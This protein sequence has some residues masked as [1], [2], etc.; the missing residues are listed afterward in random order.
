MKSQSR[1]VGYLNLTGPTQYLTLVKIIAA[2]D[3]EDADLFSDMI[4]DRLGKLL[5]HLRFFSF[6]VYLFVSFTLKQRLYRWCRR[7]CSSPVHRP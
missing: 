6:Y 1:T 2:F 3:K 5:A 4:F 7:L